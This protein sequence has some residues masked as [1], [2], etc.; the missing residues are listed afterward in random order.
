MVRPAL[1]VE[2]EWKPGPLAAGMVAYVVVRV[3]GSKEG[4]VQGEIEVRG[5]EGGI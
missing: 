2:V 3:K 4:E 5:V 1:P